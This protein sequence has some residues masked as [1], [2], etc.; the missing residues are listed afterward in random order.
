MR[1]VPRRRRA[2]SV[3]V[4]RAANTPAITVPTIARVRFRQRINVAAV[5]GD[6]TSM[7]SAIRR[8]SAA[9]SES[10]APIAF[11]PASANT[12]TRTAP[13]SSGGAAFGYQGR[14]RSQ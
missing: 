9:V 6:G 7:V 12:G 10:P 4:C 8:G 11:T 5:L 1:T 14:N 3:R 13:K 2:T